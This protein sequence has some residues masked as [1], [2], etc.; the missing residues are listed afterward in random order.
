[1]QN[2][3]RGIATNRPFMPLIEA[4]KVLDSD[5]VCLHHVSEVLEA[6]LAVLLFLC[7]AVE[8]LRTEIHWAKNTFNGPSWSCKLR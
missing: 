7:S 5:D 3:N 4:R 2:S 8:V 1:M 6:S